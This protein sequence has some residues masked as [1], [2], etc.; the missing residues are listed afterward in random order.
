M[1]A[2]VGVRAAEPSMLNYLLL[3]LVVVFL[4]AGLIALGVGHKRWNWGTVAAAI[5]TLLT[6][7]GFL[8][9]AGRMAAY[10]WSWRRV[11]EAKQTRLAEVEDGRVP[12]GPGGRL[13][14]AEGVASLQSLRE[15]KARWERAF[16][17]VDSWRG[18][19]WEH[20]SFQPPTVGGDAADGTVELNLAAGRAAAGTDA[21]GD[22]DAVPPEAPPPDA[23]GDPAAKAAAGKPPLDVG[24]TVYL[25]DERTTDAGGRYLGALTVTAIEF[26]AAR[27]TCTLTVAPTE[28]P[29]DYDRTVWS[30]AYDKTVTVY[31]RLPNDRWLAF[32]QTPQDDD[33]SG[34]MPPVKSRSIEDVEKMIA[35]LDAGSDLATEVKDHDVR[36]VPKEE[37]PAVRARLDDKQALP[38]EYWAK[39]KLTKNV[40]SLGAALADEDARAEL[41]EGA[42]VEFDLQTAFELQD[43]ELATI[44]EVRYRRPLRD[45]GT[46]LHG[47]LVAGGRE[48]EDGPPIP[49]AGVAGMVESVRREKAILEAW[50]E[51]LDK[52]KQSLETE[53]R[54]TSARKQAY[55]ADLETWIR[56]ADEATRLATAF[57]AELARSEAQRQAIGAD[58][59]RLAGELRAAMGA[60]VARIDS[61]APPPTQGA[62]AA[63]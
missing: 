39:V 47:G 2:P 9:L 11:I 43:Q 52:A 6:A 18:S 5:L 30:E 28:T 57:Q 32:S 4:V 42:E 10:E 56:D 27:Q 29:D 8:V 63:P 55:A 60:L 35:A 58:V 1:P 48:G 20:C 17:R 37:W 3:G 7:C 15:M 54:A 51:R 53:A 62:A 50:L 26:D 45:S 23:A 13:V 24:A 22:A 31:D 41:P 36:M 21:G 33:G 38:G 25:F 34:V 44:E 12:R 40:D 19:R 59:I 49:V 14:P 46:L 16:D 61:V